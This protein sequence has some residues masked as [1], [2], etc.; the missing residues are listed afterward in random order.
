[1]KRPNG[2]YGTAYPDA[3][4]VRQAFNQDGNN[5]HGLTIGG[6]SEIAQDEGNGIKELRSLSDWGITAID[7]SNSRYEFS[8]DSRP[9]GVDY[10]R[11]S[12][13]TLEAQEE[14]VLYTPVGAGLRPGGTRHAAHH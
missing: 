2:S 8:S 6:H 12:T 14:G 3:P 9:N 5:T 13:Q 7:C 10:G 4:M 11:I 1:M